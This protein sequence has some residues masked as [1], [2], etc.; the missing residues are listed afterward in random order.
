MARPQRELRRMAGVL[1][2]RLPEL[3]L[4]ED[5]DPRSPRGRRWRSIGPH[6]RSILVG[7]LSGATG[8]AT[9]EALTADLS[10]SMRRLLGIA[11]RI[12]DTSLRNVLVKLDL[13]SLRQLIYRQVRAAH[14][15][16][17]LGPHGLPFGIVSIDGKATQLPC[18]DEHLVMRQ[19]SADRRSAFGLMRTLTAVLQSSRAKVCIDAMPIG[20]R[21]N[22][23]ASLLP[24]IDALQR[25]YGALNLFRL[26]TA[27]A[28]L[29]S[30]DNAAGLV[31]RKLDYLFALKDDQP[32]LFAEAK[33]LLSR[34]P[35]AQAQAQTEDVTG[36]GV[37][38]RR[39]YLSDD[40]AGFHDWDHLR[41]VLRVE[42]IVTHKDT[43]AVLRH[44]NRYTIIS[45]QADRLTAD[46]W[47]R[48][49]RERWSVENQ[50]HWTFDAILKE[51]DHPWIEDGEDGPNGALAALLLRRVAYNILALTR[52]VTL[53][54]EE[55]RA[56]PFADLMR[57][58]YNTLIAA[59]DH[60]VAAL[61]P[62]VAACC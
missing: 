27:D 28:G 35:P 7:M 45:L 47:L 42:S 24:A 62:R 58:I 48:V 39:L 17:A 54:S 11:R 41:V 14:R 12:A 4:G 43:G 50:G 15:R 51:D 1:N 37:V 59:T 30:R 49:I 22:E 13:D 36:R 40:I 21:T 19:R 25:A 5:I 18:W 10:R 44:D 53:R 31:A 23:G 20:A 38:T 2:A 57:S 34:Q 16:H 33:R 3:H 56:R 6:L 8:L 26:V 55:S 29:C 61:R 52:S 9:V 46:Q 60:T 32:T